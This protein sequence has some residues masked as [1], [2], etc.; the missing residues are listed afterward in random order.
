M[1]WLTSA[2]A[3]GRIAEELRR[4]PP[5]LVLHHEGDLYFVVAQFCWLAAF[6]YEPPAFLSIG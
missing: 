1:M 2:R 6:E 4:E 3:F 5:R